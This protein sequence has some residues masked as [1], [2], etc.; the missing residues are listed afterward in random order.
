MGWGTDC[1][2][3]DQE[4]AWPCREQEGQPSF[5]EERVDRCSEGCPLCFED[6][7][8]LRYQEGHS[9]LH[10]GKGVVCQVS[11]VPCYQEGC[12][13]AGLIA[14]H[15]KASVRDVGMSTPFEQ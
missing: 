13:V 10:E 6:Q 15:E 7:G 2:Q 14:E 5:Q 3:V 12:A 9:P 8:V 1:W 11:K 4:Q